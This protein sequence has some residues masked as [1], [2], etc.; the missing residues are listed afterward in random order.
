MSE[1]KP[2]IYSKICEVMSA[3]GAIGKNK[4]NTGQGYKFRGIDDMFNALHEHFVN[5]GIFAVPRVLNM[6]REER[7]TPKGGTLLYT[8][9]EVEYSIY[10]ADGSSVVCVTTGEAMD[11]GD[12]SCNKAM[13]AAL[14]YALMQI[15]CIP[16][17][18]KLD[19]EYENHEVAPRQQSSLQRPAQAP[20]RPQNG[21]QQGNGAMTWNDSWTMP[22]G[23][24]K[25]KRVDELSIDDL[26]FYRDSALQS[27]NEGKYVERNQALVTRI[28]QEARARQAVN[29][30]A[31][32]E[33]DPELGNS[34][35]NK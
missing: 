16:T 29:P 25:G 18:E 10:A 11:S 1:A 5:A 2:L 35:G 13:S 33:H 22:F 28:T 15:F 34:Y 20:Q 24:S 26:K 6:T 17:E 32:I 12:K 7:Q 4:K 3:V 31:D 21:Q 9:L 14:K 30:E 27:I 23:K 19:T 8:I